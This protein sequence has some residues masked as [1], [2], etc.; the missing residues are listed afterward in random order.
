MDK[1]KERALH[2]ERSDKI[3]W[4]KE[5]LRMQGVALF[6]EDEEKLIRL[7]RDFDHVLDQLEYVEK[8]N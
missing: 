5:N 3:D 7:K 2:T 4:L 8:I 1:N 6:M